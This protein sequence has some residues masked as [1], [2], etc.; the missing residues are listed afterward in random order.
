MGFNADNG[1]SLCNYNGCCVRYSCEQSC[2][3]GTGAC[4]TRRIEG[5]KNMNIL[6]LRDV[7]KIYGDLKALNN[8]N[9][10]VEKSE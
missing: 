2:R 8:I 3:C 5:G 9:L 4:F 7:S 6:T 10:Q 1:I